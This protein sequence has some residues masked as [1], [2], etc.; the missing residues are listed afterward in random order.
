MDACGESHKLLMVLDR[1]NPN[2]FYVDGPIVK[3]KFKTI[4]GAFPIPIVY[5]LTP[6]E[7][8]TMGNAERWI[9]HYPCP[10]RIIK[11]KGYSHK[12]HYKLP[13]KPSPNIT[14]MDAVYLYPTLCLFEGTAMS[15]GRGTNTPFHSVGYPGYKDGNVKFT[16]RR[17]VIAPRPRYR[18]T[19]VTAMDVTYAVKDSAKMPLTLNIGWIIKMYNSYPDKKH[20]FN[21]YFDKLAGN[22]AMR[23]QIMKGMSEDQI[24]AS[25]KEDIDA[26]MKLRK[27]YLLYPDFGE[28]RKRVVRK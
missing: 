6:A 23:Q 2:S 16:P 9:R 26:Y 28:I 15:V 22:S 12:M 14:D 25:W 5:A 19:L 17:K 20:F 18:D 1:P 10:V 8:V 11:M 4:L 21:V 7:I 27:L 13:V 24:R 3:E